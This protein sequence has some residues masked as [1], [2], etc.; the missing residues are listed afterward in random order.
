MVDQ[1]NRV[2]VSLFFT[3]LITIS[4]L[5]DRTCLILNIKSETTWCSDPL[6]VPIKT[7]IHKKENSRFL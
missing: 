6:K 4:F 3:S 7:A 5:V 1:G 2:E